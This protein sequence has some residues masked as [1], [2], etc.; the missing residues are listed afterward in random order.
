MNQGPLGLQNLSS[1]PLLCAAPSCDPHMM[2]ALTLSTQTAHTQMH[3]ATAREVT[4]LRWKP[5]SSLHFSST[6]S[7]SHA[8]PGT[9][10]RSRQLRVLG[11]A[12]H[13]AQYPRSA[14]YNHL[15]RAWQGAGRGTFG[16]RAHTGTATGL[17]MSTR[18]RTNA[19]HVITRWDT[20]LHTPEFLCHTTRESFPSPNSIQR[21]A[22]KPSP[23]FW[24]AGILPHPGWA[25]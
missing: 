19:A 8:W 18:T 5:L 10:G 1:R 24:P 21:D 14:R 9:V 23:R 15:P 12:A 20:E 3:Q 16:A 22:C 17:Y 6:P 13:S 11:M 7:G 25:G 2:L 4:Q